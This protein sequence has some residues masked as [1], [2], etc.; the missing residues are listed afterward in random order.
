V[1]SDGQCARNFG[2]AFDI[3]DVG[4]C[5]DLYG[6]VV[7]CLLDRLRN[8]LTQYRAD[9]KAKSDIPTVADVLLNKT[10]IA[11]P[12]QTAMFAIDIRHTFGHHSR[13]T[14]N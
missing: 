5:R 10:G 7:A 13:R 3:W 12:S 8:L 14:Y 9:I 6:L 4:S 11:D 2:D 1:S